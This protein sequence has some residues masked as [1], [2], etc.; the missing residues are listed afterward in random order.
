MTSPPGLAGR[1]ATQAPAHL[2]IEGLW[3]LQHEQKL[4]VVDLQ[5]HACDLA[6]QLGVGVVDQGVQTLTC[7]EHLADIPAARGGG[8]GY[9]GKE[10]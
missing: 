3:G 9:C 2:G 5:Q 6:G 8:G 4:R 10:G 7:T 1:P